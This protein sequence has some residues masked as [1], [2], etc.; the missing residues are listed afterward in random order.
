MD[1]DLAINLMLVAASTI[2]SALDLVDFVTLLIQVMRVEQIPSCM[3]SATRID[4]AAP[5]EASPINWL[6]IE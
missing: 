1:Y 4:L 2:S 3:S 6:E 5:G